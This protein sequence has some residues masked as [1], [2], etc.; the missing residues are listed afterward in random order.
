MNCS[1]ASW[2]LLEELMLELKK[3]GAIIPPKVIDDLRT[4]KSMTGLACM[5][6][7]DDVIAKT[8]GLFSA[9]ESYLVTESQKRF[10]AQRVDCWLRRLEVAN[11]ETR[12]V[13]ETVKTTFVA[14][15]PKDMHWFRIEPVGAL[16]ADQIKQLSKEQD[17]WV[18][19]QTD[20]RLV[21]Y[22]SSKNLKLFIKK[23][24]QKNRW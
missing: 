9:V 23:L 22:G 8:V 20:G 24:Y 16:S 14:G 6:C 3:S 1:W 11:S 12:L 15:V 2:K 5:R 19:S 4:I 21:V 7:S 13:S 17:L 10:D 18:E